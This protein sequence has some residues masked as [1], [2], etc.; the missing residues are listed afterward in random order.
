MF[1]G[2]VFKK[3]DHEQTR[4]NVS[5]ITFIKKTQKLHGHLRRRRQWQQWFREG[6]GSE[7]PSE[8][9]QLCES[10]QQQQQ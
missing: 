5:T 6:A 9:G 1:F 7:T 4:N 2:I 8:C 10:V 3:R